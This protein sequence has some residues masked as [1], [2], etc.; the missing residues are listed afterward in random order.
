VVLFCVFFCAFSSSILFGR[1]FVS[2]DGAWGMKLNSH[3]Y[4]CVLFAPHKKTGVI[5]RFTLRVRSSSDCNRVPYGLT[6]RQSQKNDVGVWRNWGMAMY[7]VS[8]CVPSASLYTPF[9]GVSTLPLLHL[10]CFGMTFFW[11]GVFRGSKRDVGFY[12]PF[13]SQ[14]IFLNCF[15]SSFMILPP[16]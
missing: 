3:H 16:V 8:N 15:P 11:G 9:C 10:F 7:I 4:W 13:A 6:Y 14:T 2:G 5:W 1:S 12:F